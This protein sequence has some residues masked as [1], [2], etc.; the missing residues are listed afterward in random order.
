MSLFASLAAML[1]CPA[2]ADLPMPEVGASWDYVNPAIDAPIGRT[3][4]EI[5]TVDGWAVTHL[6]SAQIDE[7]GT[8]MPARRITAVLGGA[9][10][11]R[12]ESAEGGR[13]Q[14]QAIDPADIDSILN[15]T[16]GQSVEVAQKAGDSETRIAVHFERCV[17]GEGE[18]GPASMYHIEKNGDSREVTIAH[19]SGWWVKSSSAAGVIELES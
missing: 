2:Y 11:V 10:P 17:S 6:H 4:Y 7:D 5:E 16:E 18:N 19:D 3:R 15:L 1:S 9:I 12:M 13:V 8:M 14:D